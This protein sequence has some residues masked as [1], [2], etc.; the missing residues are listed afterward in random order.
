MRK[1]LTLA[2]AAMS[3]AWVVPAVADAPDMFKDLD[4]NHWAYQ[5]T[6]ALR[7]KNIV[8]GYPDG[9]FRGR[10]TL[11]RYEFAVALDRAL[12]SIKD[13]QKGDTGPAGPAGP[14]GSTGPEG[15]QG[16]AGAQGPSGMAPEDVEK[17]RKLAQEFQAELGALG[18]SV[19]AV[20][21]K[22]DGL[23]KQVADIKAAWDK[24]PKI[25]GMLWTG[26]RADVSNG[27][28]VDYDGR[29]NP[30][31]G[32]LKY[33]PVVLHQLLLEIKAKAG[34]GAI[35][36]G[37]VSDNYK[38]YTGNTAQVGG[39]NGNPAS[40]T[41]LHHLTFTAG[42]KVD[43]RG[44]V[45]TIGRFGHHGN[46]L[47]L[48]KPDG[49]RLFTSTVYDTPAYYIDGVKWSGNVGSL[50]VNVFGGETKSVAGVY[51]IPLNSPRAGNGTGNIFTGGVK[52]MAMLLSG[53]QTVDQLFGVET[54]LPLHILTN[55]KLGFAVY[56]DYANSGAS[57]GAG[58]FTNTLVLNGTLETSLSE[59][60]SF[61]G[62]WG[63]A[64]TGT[65][66]LNTV[67]NQMNSAF[68][69]S[70]GYGAGKVMVNAGYKY[71]DPLYYA[72]GY[73]GRI[74]NWINPVNIQGPNVK[75]GFDVSK[76]VGVNL[77]GEFYTSAHDL[78]V[79]G[80]GVGGL[81]RDDEINRVVA[82]VKWSVLKNLNINA[83]W[84]G[85]FWKLQGTHTGLGTFSG[86]VHPTENYITIGTGLNLTNSTQL[87]LSY[88]IGDFN[89][90]SV[91]NSGV[92]NT[93]NFNTF[94]SQVNVKF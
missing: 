26:A 71:I 33:N 38:N 7:Q 35:D 11:T 36:A 70:F 94:V 20:N 64:N 46:S 60:L 53:Q 23:A 19:K 54:S 25:S 48:W 67:N 40:D 91:L 13:P 49:D 45:V 44:S 30:A 73:W 8:W 87:K 4:Q 2:G 66:R 6:E 22:V 57:A 92:G 21:A 14:A 34:G 17:L 32:Q 18:N 28:Y 42:T 88:V 62:Q 63:K 75:L 58:G 43:G 68:I 3:L 84:E 10:R 61:K 29:T 80:Q 47:A 52:P 39:L 24:A 31:G 81:G 59:K 79:G 82:A 41:Y 55:T 51:N 5:A 76:N 50:G 9:Y 90:H 1:G 72:P 56:G 77:S 15:V 12:K 83:E 85:V 37:L 27:G 74:G 65:G 16:P 69:G 89:G 78:A 86:S 93:N